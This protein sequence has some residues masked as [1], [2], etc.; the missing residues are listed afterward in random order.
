MA[1]PTPSAPVP[2]LTST[3]DPTPYVPVSWM[4]VA[5]LSV[6]GLFLLLLVAFGL[7]AFTNKK[8]LL[9]DWLLVLPILALILSFAARRVIRNSEGTRT[10]ENLAVT[11]WWMALVLGL[12]YIAYLFAIDYSVRN[13]AKG[14]VQRWETL[15]REDKIAPA[16]Y[17]TLPP[18][19]RQGMRADDRYRFQSEFRDQFVMFETC[20]LVRLVQ[21]NK[22]ACEFAHGSVKW[23][24]K[25]GVIECLYTGTVRCPEGTFPV[26]VSLRGSE[27]VTGPEGGGG[28]RQWAI[29]PPSS[30]FIDHQGATRTPYGWLVQVLELNGAAFGKEFVGNLAGGP[31][32]QPYLYQGFIRPGGD[33]FAWG[34][35]ASTTPARVG[36]AGG[37]AAA[38]PYGNGFTQYVETQF[39]RQPGGGNP[40]DEKR[41]AFLK[42]W[43]A[44][45]LAPAG[46][47]LKDPS[48]TVADK[49]SV[50]AITDAAV[51]VRVPVE[52]PILGTGKMEA[53]R[54]RLVVVCTDPALLAELKQLKGTADP[55]AGT[56]YFPEDLRRRTFPWRVVRVESDMVP[57]SPGPPGGGMGM[58]PP[59]MPEPVG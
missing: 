4:A 16:F 20:D 39:F 2:A 45:G 53:A 35:I 27:G 11:A 46:A 52:I 1:E 47:R 23:S 58:E 37:L 33:R 25:P 9:M 42:S 59:T 54:G 32:V 30:G 19:R 8:P 43:Y 18:G 10:G 21:R 6:S 31:S 5:A 26:N 17:R 48:G 38:V 57:L 15:L 28:G 7:D 24:Y 29:L 55:A 44:V 49:E 12:G 50:I 40:T 56:S 13:D 36:G 34:A 51:E 22:D 3:A 41:A 14:E